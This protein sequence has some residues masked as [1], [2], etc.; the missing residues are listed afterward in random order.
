MTTDNPTSLA[1]IRASSPGSRTP[2]DNAL[3]GSAAA[4]APAPAQAQ[5]DCLRHPTF[6]PEGPPPMFPNWAQ[7]QQMQHMSKH[8]E[9]AR[10]L[11]VVGVFACPLHC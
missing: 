3:A 10:S 9:F 6:L 4:P 2:W 11:V 7:Q 5:P 8:V 1:V